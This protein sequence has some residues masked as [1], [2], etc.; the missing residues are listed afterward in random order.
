M[1]LETLSTSIDVDSSKVKDISVACTRLLDVQKQN[2]RYRE[3]IKRDS[4][5]GA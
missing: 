1:D 4:R 5:T 2:S 3:S